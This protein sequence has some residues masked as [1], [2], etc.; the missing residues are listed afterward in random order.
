MVMDDSG[1]WM[2]SPEKTASFTVNS[3]CGLC[4]LD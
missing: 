1:V 2:T 4:L 3:P